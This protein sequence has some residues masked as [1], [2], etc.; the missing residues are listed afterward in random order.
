MSLSAGANFFF[1]VLANDVVVIGPGKA[2][3]ESGRR[4]RVVANVRRER[5]AG[6]ARP[7]SFSCGEVHRNRLPSSSTIPGEQTEN[8]KRWMNPT[9]RTVGKREV[10]LKVT[11]SLRLVCAFGIDVCK[12]SPRTT[13][14]S[15]AVLVWLL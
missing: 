9:H 4:Q 15:L 1:R 3:L 11:H 2:A 5:S 8:Q 12:Y 6:Q 13:A 7:S 14:E 10:D